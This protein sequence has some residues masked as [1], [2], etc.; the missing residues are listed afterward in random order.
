MIFIT[1]GTEYIDIDASACAF[2]YKE[3]L[4]KQDID[5][6]IILPKKQT[7]TIP[8]E[9]RNLKYKTDLSDE[10]KEGAEYVLVDISH[11]DHISKK[12]DKSEILKIYDHH[13]GFKDYWQGCT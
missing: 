2:A 11:P 4:D 8:K 1:A 3:L 10:I 6:M 9:F 7:T 12:I 13:L 5:G